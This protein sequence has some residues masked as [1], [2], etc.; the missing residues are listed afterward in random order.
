MDPQDDDA[1]TTTRPSA[2]DSKVNTPRALTS[3]TRGSL[4]LKEINLSKAS[5]SREPASENVTPFVYVI[6]TVAWLAAPASR[7]NVD[8]DRG[9]TNPTEATRTNTVSDT[10]KVADVEFGP[11]AACMTTE[12]GF[13][14]KRR[15]PDDAASTA[16]LSLEFS[17]ARVVTSYATNGASLRYARTFAEA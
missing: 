11:N 5:Q 3:T 8:E 14:T 1:D 7:S 2:L 12:P 10:N 9:T 6:L 15:E 4:E 17:D 16:E 13:F